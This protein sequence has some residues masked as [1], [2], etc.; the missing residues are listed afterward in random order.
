MGLEHSMASNRYQVD[1]IRFI[2][3]ILV[4]ITIFTLSLYL[5]YFS[6]IEYQ[7]YQILCKITDKILLQELKKSTFD[8][9]FSSKLF[10]FDSSSKLAAQ[11]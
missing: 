6:K 10:H 8:L 3:Y 7:H 2:V 9:A 5:V 4:Y 1:E 11:L